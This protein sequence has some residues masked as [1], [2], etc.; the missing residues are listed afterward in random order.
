[1]CLMFQDREFKPKMDANNENIE[2]V[3]DLALDYSIQCIQSRLNSDSG[4]GAN[5]GSVL[6][7]TFVA[8]EPL[9]ELVW[10]TDKG[11]GPS[12]VN[13]SPPQSITGGRPI[14]EKPLEE[15]NFIASDTSFRVKSEAAGKDAL[16]MSPT[17]DAGVMLAHGSSHESETETIP[18]VEE[19]KTAMEVSILH[20]QLDTCGPINF[21]IDEIPEMPETGEN[22]LTTLP[23]DVDR[24]R[25]NMMQPD[26]IIP[27][28]EQSEPLLEDP[29]GEDIRAD[30]GNP[31]REMD[32]LLTSKA[33]LVNESRDSGAFVVDQISQ[34]SRPLDKM[35]ST[36]DNDVQIL[37]SENAYG[38]ASQKLGSECLLRDKDSFEKVEELLP[39][40]DSVLDKHS[41]TNSRI[42]K[43]RRKGKEKAL[44][45][46]DLS[47]RRSKKAVSDG[48]ISGRMSNEGDDSHESVESCNSARLVS[49]G[50]KR[51][52]FE[53]QF[54]VG[55]K[56]FRKQIQETPGC[57]SYVKQD[58]S[59]MN[60]ISCMMKGFSKSIQDEAL[61]LTVVHPDHARESSDKKLITY[62]KNQDAGIKSIGFQSIFKSLYCPRAEDQGTRISSGNHEIRERPEELK[63]AIIP[64]GF[65]GEKMNLGKGCL[66]PVGKFNESTCCNEVGSAIQPETL[67]AKVAG[68][69][70]KGNNTDSVENKC[71]VSSTS[72]LGKRKKTSVEH[73]ESDPQP[74]GK[75]TDKFDHRRDLLGSLWVTRFTPKI[76]GLSLMSDRYSVGAVL[77]C[78]NDKN[79]VGVEEQSVEDIVSVSGNEPRECAA[80]NAGSLAF[81]RNK[82]QS[83]EKSVSKLNPMF[84]APKFGGT[85]AMAS[86]FARRLDALKHISPSGI[87][88]NAADKIMT[89]FFCG[90]KGHHLRECSQIKDTELQDLSS[91]FK[92]Y[93]G[94]EYLSSFCIRCF[95]CNHWA[96]ACPNA[97]SVGQPQLECNL[98]YYCSPN[99]TKLNA[100]GNMKLLT[101]EESQSEASVDQDDSRLQTD[102]NLS[103]KSNSASKKMRHSSNSVKRYSASSSGQTK[104]KQKSVIPLSQFVNIPVTDVPKGISDSVKRLRLSRTDVLKWMDSHTSLSNLEGFFLRLRLGK[105]ET[106]LGGTRYYVS[107][108]TGTT[109]SQRESHPQN[110]KNSISVIVGGIRCVVEAQY[111]SNHDFL[112]DELRAWWSATTKNNAKIPS[113]EDL[114]EKI[115][116]KKLL[117]L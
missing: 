8:T 69:Q 35:E 46:G 103:W 66:L 4:A 53:E 16:T 77:D 105:S 97:T 67:S 84:P 101:G 117:G 78:S 19:V 30:D 24:E 106:G 34:G 113:I 27:F 15:E 20:K 40:N 108:I 26:Q 28:V 50:K 48:N 25:V 72:S 82:S 98:S 93:N 96:V 114:R 32:F 110:A 37:R 83:D 57:S 56:R 60:W 86:V 89:C 2:P 54:I 47:G 99:Q 13:L 22:F 17:S 59:F 85:E 41:P 115:E 21:K 3:T 64:K 107:C 18:N 81:N 11:A 88:G 6:G 73:V 33:Y 71:G 74:E 68:S 29:V 80:D 5:A 95:E 94:A 51:W 43:H 87:T 75:T 79:N 70:E 92:S 1:M 44:S 112:E 12:N 65:H 42:H 14:S 49:S 111:V 63:Q 102:L 52:G 61:P 31:S 116:M 58:S 10:S 62:N 9:S 55:T 23:G 45:D 104:I 90:I 7:M 38:A 109:G 100:E 76:S 36:A 39:V 91:K